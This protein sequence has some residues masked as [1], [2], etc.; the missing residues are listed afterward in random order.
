M[1]PLEPSNRSGLDGLSQKHSDMEGLQSPFKE[2]VLHGFRA[3]CLGQ[4]FGFVNKSA[5]TFLVVFN[6][7]LLEAICKK[8]QICDAF[9]SSNQGVQGI[10]DNNIGNCFGFR[11]N[12]DPK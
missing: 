10:W 11:N 12:V 3:L 5:L 8:A 6:T 4:G 9:E 1:K 2:V 7:F